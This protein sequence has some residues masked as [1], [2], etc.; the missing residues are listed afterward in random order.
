MNINP[1]DEVEIIFH[2]KHGVS[3]LLM[4]KLCGLYMACLYSVHINTID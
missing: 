2:N 3:L 1:K 4:L